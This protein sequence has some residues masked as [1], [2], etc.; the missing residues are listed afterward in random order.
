MKLLFL[1]LCTAALL[2]TTNARAE[3]CTDQ[4]RDFSFPGLT[5]YQSEYVYQGN[6]SNGC[7]CPVVSDGSSACYRGCYT[8]CRSGGSIDTPG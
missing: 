5:S 7:N 2:V 4:D 8:E 3:N 6:Y 1:I